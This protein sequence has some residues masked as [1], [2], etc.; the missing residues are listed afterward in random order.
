MTRRAGSQGS[1]LPPVSSSHVPFWQVGLHHY[2]YFHLLAPPG[3]ENIFSCNYLWFLPPISQNPDFKWNSKKH[4]SIGGSKARENQPCAQPHHTP[5][6]TG[7]MKGLCSTGS[8]VVVVMVIG[9]KYKDPVLTLGLQ[10][11]TYPSRCF[12]GFAGLQLAIVHVSRGW[13]W[14]NTGLCFLPAIGG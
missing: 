12:H 9:L 1:D 6:Y 2:L 11:W 3:N 13:L 5:Q 14:I 7:K 10:V 4:A 8:W